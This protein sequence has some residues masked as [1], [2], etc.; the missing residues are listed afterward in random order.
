ML[1]YNE[2]IIDPENQELEDLI[3]SRLND[4]TK[5]KGSLGR[6]EE[7]ATQYCICKGSADARINKKSFFVFA[8]DHGI[9]ANGVA[10]FPK[11]VTVQMINNMLSGGAAISVLCRNAGIDCHIVDMGVEGDLS[12]HKMLIQKKVARGTKDFLSDCA[13]TVEQCTAAVQ[14]G[15]EIG[16][17]CDADICGIGEMGIGNTSSAS[18]IFSLLFNKD[19]ISTVGK[20]TGADGELLE[21]KKQII[22]QAVQFHRASWN[23]TTFDALRRVGGYEIAG[24]AGFIIGSAARRNPVVVDGF[25]ATAAALCAIGIAP[26]VRNYLYFGHVSDEKFHQNVLHETGVKAIL[27]LN[28]RLG[29]GTGAAL[30]IQLIEQALNCY[31]EMATFSSAR[32]SNRGR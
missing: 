10:P 16:K 3:I 12:E 15:F 24:M 4:L 17:S 28:M 5:P 26:R 19:G 32:V 1:N 6:L 11:A 13:M 30:S 8:G 23:G 29:E 25:I 21:R 18:A 14:N 31:H 7:F 2:F 9:T 22:N 20:G 27:Q